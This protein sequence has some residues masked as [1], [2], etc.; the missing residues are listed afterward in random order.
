MKIFVFVLSHIKSFVDIDQADLLKF[1][2]WQQKDILKKIVPTIKNETY[3]SY[4][5]GLI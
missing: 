2:A 3:Q 4:G 1:I 5:P